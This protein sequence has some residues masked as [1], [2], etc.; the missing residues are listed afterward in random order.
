MPTPL[1]TI[2]PLQPDHDLIDWM[3]DIRRTI[4]QQPELAY[5]EHQTRELICSKLTELGIPFQT[6]FARTGVVA[7]IAPSGSGSATDG[8]GCVALRADMD[9]L[10]VQE[11]TG[12]PFASKLPGLMHACGHDGHVAMLLGA[13]ALLKKRDVAGRVDEGHHTGARKAGLEGDAKFG[14]STAD[15]F[16]GLVL[17]VGQFRMLMDRSPYILHPVDQIAVRLQGEEVTV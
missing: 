16:P 17:L 14:Q 7:T 13:A 5:Q 3:L 9:G 8:T 6:G 15:Q 4:H 10:P 12:L 11:K 2:A 1:T